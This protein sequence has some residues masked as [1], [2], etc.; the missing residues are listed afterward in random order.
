MKMRPGVT[1]GL[2]LLAGGAYYYYY[3]KPR[4]VPGILANQNT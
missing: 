2:I 4:R 1:G 3:Y